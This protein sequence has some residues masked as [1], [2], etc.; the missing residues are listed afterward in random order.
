MADDKLIKYEPPSNEDCQKLLRPDLEAALMKE[1]EWEL[2]KLI[3]YE[4]LKRDLVSIDSLSAPA[5]MRDFNLAFEFASRVVAKLKYFH[6]RAKERSK[7]EESKAILERA[8]MYFE[9]HNILKDKGGLKDS[10]SLRDTYAK[11]D[12]EYQ[13]AKD[14]ENM[15]EALL[16]YYEKLV[17][18]YKMAHDDAKKIYDKTTS[19]GTPYG[20]MASGGNI[21]DRTNE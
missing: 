16:E 17:E 9:K 5:Y 21:G 14:E 6:G 19:N 2:S 4:Q 7:E 15:L 13:Q 8:P 10:S 20:G 11:I 3:P 12:V 1:V 18:S